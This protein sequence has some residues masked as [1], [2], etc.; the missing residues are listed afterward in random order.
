MTSHPPPSGAA[1]YL[2]YYYACDFSYFD[3]VLSHSSSQILATP[4]HR[5]VTFSYYTD[6]SN[7]I[8]P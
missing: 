7:F 5:E 6:R 1:A 4:L 2:Y 3:V 8:V